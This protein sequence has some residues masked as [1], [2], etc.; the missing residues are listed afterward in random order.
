MQMCMHACICIRTGII[1]INDQYAVII[2]IIIIQQKNFNCINENFWWTKFH[3]AQLPLHIIEGINFHHCNNDC[4]IIINTRQKF[5]DNFL[6]W[7]STPIIIMIYAYLQLIANNYQYL[8]RISIKHLFVFGI[9]LCALLPIPQLP[10][11]FM[12]SATANGVFPQCPWVSA[13]NSRFWPTWVLTWDQNPI[14]LTMYGNCYSGPLKCSTWA[15]T[16]EWALAR[17]TTVLVI[18][19]LLQ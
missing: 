15:L 18:I 9:S 17:D 5:S 4:H 12:Q 7:Y 6:L 3:Q 13:H 14:R 8:S 10:L 19:I 16:R 1:I 11:P 2:I